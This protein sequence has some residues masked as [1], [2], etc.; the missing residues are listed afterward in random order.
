MTSDLRSYGHNP[1]RS[2]HGCYC[3]ILDFYPSSTPQWCPCDPLPSA[4][5]PCSDC[6][7]VKT[8]E[9]SM[10]EWKSNE[11]P[12]ASGSL[13]S[14]RSPEE[15]LKKSKNFW[16]D[17]PQKSCSKKNSST[18]ES[19]L[20]TNCWFK[21]LWSLVC[22]TL[23]CKSRKYWILIIIFLLSQ[24]LLQALKAGFCKDKIWVSKLIRI[25]S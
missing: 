12:E 1:W 16:L 11:Y 15:T 5:R 22:A 25:I 18:P 4:R 17:L 10:L 24:L 14:S 3:A 6:R 9:S 7:L 23:Y 13:A 19:L 20:A 2:T 21:N 8:E